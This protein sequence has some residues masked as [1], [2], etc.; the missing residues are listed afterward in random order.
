MIPERR[1]LAFGDATQCSNCGKEAIQQ[2][3]L[4]KDEVVI[5]CMNCGAARHYSSDGVWVEMRFDDRV[6]EG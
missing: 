3:E 6:S 5:I 1:L 4:G 2:I